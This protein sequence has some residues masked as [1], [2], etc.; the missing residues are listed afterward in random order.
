MD[1]LSQLSSLTGEVK[2]EEYILPHYKE[3]YRLAIDALVDGGRKTYQEFLTNEKL[4]DFLSEEELAF[5]TQNAEKPPQVNPLD[6]CEDIQDDS[7]STGTYWPVESDVETPDL[8]IGWPGFL[9]E[10]SKKTNVDL[11]FHPPRQNCPTIKEVIRKSIQ[12]A[13]KVIAI[14]MD[15]F[16]DVD[17][18]KEIV[19]ASVRGV[20]VYI[21]LDEF[22]FKS[23][24]TMAEKQGVQVQRLR[25]MRVRTIKGQEYL[26]RS[27]AKFHG[28]LEQKFLLVDCHTVVYGSYSFMWSFEK[29]NLSMVQVITGQLVECYDEEFRTLFA[30]STIPNVFAPENVAL[31]VKQERW[32]NGT[33]TVSSYVS[34]SQ[35]F[36]KRDKLRHTLDTVYMKACGRQL[37]VANN[38]GDMDN[39]EKYQQRTF[40]YRP[41]PTG[42]NVQNRIQQLQSTETSNYSKRHSYAGEKEETPLY[43]QNRA[44]NFGPSNWNVGREHDGYG[45][46]GRTDFKSK[47]NAFQG[48]GGEQFQKGRLTQPYRSNMRKSFH[49]TDNHVRT[50]QQNMPTLERTTKSFLRTWRIESYLNNSESPLEDCGDYP[51]AQY[52]GLEGIENKPNQMYPVHSRLRSSL[53]FKSTIPEQLETNSYASNLSTSTMSRSQD[54]HINSSA[55]VYYAAVHRNPAMQTENRMRQDDF[56]QKRRSLQIYDDQKTHMNY[57]A[58]KESFIPV[59]ATLGR[60]S[61]KNPDVLHQVEGYGYKRHSINEPKPSQDYSANKDNSS[62]MY[63]TLGRRQPDKY[64]TSQGNNH[65]QNKYA[66]QN[67]DGQRSTSQHSVKMEA[68]N[69]TLSTS[70]WQPPPSRTVSATSLADSKQEEQN[71]GKANKE[72]EGSPRFFKRSTKKIKSLLNLTDK[73]PKSKRSSN[74]KICDSSDTLVSDDEDQKHK[75]NKENNK[76]S[77]S[78]ANSVKSI[79]SLGHSKI[80]QKL[81][82][83]ENHFSEKVADSSAPRF[84]TEQLNSE[85]DKEQKTSAVV[86]PAASSTVVHHQPETRKV[87]P[88]NSSAVSQALQRNRPIDKRVYSRF[89]SFCTFENHSSKPTDSREQTATTGAM[90]TAEKNKNVISDHGR[91]NAA[92]AHHTPMGYQTYSHNDNKI[93]RFMQRFVGNLIHKHK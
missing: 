15:V 50:L 83:K 79:D 28:A 56:V 2:P 68:E 26:C 21:L 46:P 52:D 93:G 82:L 8:D 33:N 49:G 19:D 92:S 85:T 13:R 4:G 90:Y 63:G 62:Y 14:V 74:Y 29:I 58:N 48:G 66:L 37:N 55:N 6:P 30:R 44:S 27:G 81:Q 73:S 20:P 60:T 86:S 10:L 1:S 51:A 32:Q 84:S 40:G 69:N 65:T 36:D 72:S 91:T 17:I 12:D 76:L 59:Y 80:N 35:P 78:T 22:Q 71:A 87:H 11:Y 3:S 7:S 53:V 31:D 34:H 57:A 47:F 64:V 25:N 9:P 5:I 38:M 41:G 89:E 23:F 70:N 43:V 16:T 67:L 77:T 24:L 88:E 75:T 39:N 61:A 42:L 45:A 54:K 18:F